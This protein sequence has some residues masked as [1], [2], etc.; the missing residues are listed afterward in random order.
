MTNTV[1]ITGSGRDRVGI[2][3]E[4]AAALFDV[5]CNLLDSSMTLLRGEFALI[6]MVAL[7]DDLAVEEL[8]KKVDALQSR[9]QLTLSLRVLAPEELLEHETERFQFIVSVYGADKPGIVA[10]ITRTLA[11]L[12]MNVSDVQ[13]KKIS[14]G[15]REIFVMMLELSSN[16][17]V[18]A[19]FLTERLNPHCKD[20]GVD[21][22]VRELEV[23][24]L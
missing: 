10:G 12:D 3:A 19:A 4:L 15:E 9:L 20:L 6:L 2:V 18:S 5:G 13:T 14:Q 21:L 7:P 24:E 11:D 1:V 23:M 17:E 16:K 22:T 8:K